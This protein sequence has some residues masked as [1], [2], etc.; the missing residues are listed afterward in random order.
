MHHYSKFF[1]SNSVYE[2]I[3]EIFFNI[4]M[5]STILLFKLFIVKSFDFNS[6]DCLLFS[7]V[8]IFVAFS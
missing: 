1:S 3:Q 7:L 2:K 6:S 8:Y 5:V 4:D